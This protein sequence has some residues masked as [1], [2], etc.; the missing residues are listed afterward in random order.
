MLLGEYSKEIFAEVF[1]ILLLIESTLTSR[2]F[3]YS[4][5]KTQRMASNCSDYWLFS[6]LLY[7]FRLKKFGKCNAQKISPIFPPYREQVTGG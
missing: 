2:G 7:T 6:L 5:V 1:L 3:I 4:V